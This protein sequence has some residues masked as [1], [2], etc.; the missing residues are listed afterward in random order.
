MQ[1]PTTIK[2]GPSASR[3]LQACKR[4]WVKRRSRIKNAKW[5]ALL[6]GIFC[7]YKV[8]SSEPARGTNLI[9]LFQSA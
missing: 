1:D 8:L 3:Y 7:D 2:S 5:R 4:R 9:L 6:E